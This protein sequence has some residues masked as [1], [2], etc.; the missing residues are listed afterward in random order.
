MFLFFQRVVLEH[1]RFWNVS[2]FQRVV[3]EYQRF[4][5]VSFFQRV[6]LEYRLRGELERLRG[7]Y[8]FKKNPIVPLGRS[9]V[10]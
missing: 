2:F 6:V 10:H 1:K 9:T 4:W 3:L 5:N 7:A 8:E